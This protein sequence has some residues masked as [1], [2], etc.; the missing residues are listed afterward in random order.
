MNLEGEVTLGPQLV[1]TEEPNQDRPRS[2]KWT[3][4]DS[5]TEATGMGLLQSLSALGV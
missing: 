1:K 4:M 2:S 5:D 3:E